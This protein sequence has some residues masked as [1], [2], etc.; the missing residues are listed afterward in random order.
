VPLIGAAARDD[1]H[2]A[3]ARAAKLHGVV[4]VD[5]AEFLHRF[6]RR[7]AALD[8]RGRRNVVGAVNGDEIIMNV[9]AGEGELGYRLDDHVSVSRG[10]IAYGDGGESKAKSINSR[11]LTGRF[12]IWFSVITVLTWVRVGSASSEVASTSTL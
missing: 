6:L 8:T 4:G 2:N 7:R 10:G 11:P 5:D 9:L 1:I 3:R 12:T